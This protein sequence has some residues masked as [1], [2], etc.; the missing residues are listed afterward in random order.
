[1][2]R[3]DEILDIIYGGR[4]KVQKLLIGNTDWHRKNDQSPKKAAV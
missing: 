4:K 1:M 3:F 2:F